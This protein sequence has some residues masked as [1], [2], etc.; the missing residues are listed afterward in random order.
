MG[1]DKKIDKLIS[2]VVYLCYPV[3]KIALLPVLMLLFGI[4]EISKIALIFL[5]VVFQVIVSVRDATCNIEPQFFFPLYSLGASFGDIFRE[6]LLPAVLPQLITALRLALGTAVSVLFFAETYGT[7]L[8]MGYFITDA[9]MRVN[10]LDMYAGIIML[11]LMGLLLF[12]L[13]DMAER[14]ACPWQNK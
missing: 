13:L 4:G 10:Y 12:A 11:A 5:I 9:W 6:V 7:Q 3:P 8:G 14:L 2:P 1:Y